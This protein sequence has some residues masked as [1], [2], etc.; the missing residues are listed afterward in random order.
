ME[1]RKTK[2]DHADNK[3]HFSIIAGHFQPFRAVFFFATLLP[4]QGPALNG[5]PTG[6][7]KNGGKT[8]GKRA[9]KRTEPGGRPSTSLGTSM[10]ATPTLR[11]N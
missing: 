7:R 4:D 8:D 2:E 3:G 11:T 10:L 6:C 9:G 1:T 5:R